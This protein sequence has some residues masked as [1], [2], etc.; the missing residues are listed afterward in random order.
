MTTSNPSITQPLQP[1][2]EDKNLLAT[3]SEST[4]ACGGGGGGCGGN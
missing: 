4:C 3:A 1:V 2:G